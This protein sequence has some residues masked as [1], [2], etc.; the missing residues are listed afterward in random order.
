[1]EEKFTQYIEAKFL[2]DGKRGTSGVVHAVYADKMKQCL[3]NPNSS[4]QNIRIYCN[5]RYTW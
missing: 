5:L 1:M 2:S 3:K 4:F